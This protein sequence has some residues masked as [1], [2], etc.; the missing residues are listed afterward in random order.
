LP[1]SGVPA[2]QK[3][4]FMYASEVYVSR[5]ESRQGKH[6]R[7]LTFLKNQFRFVANALCAARRQASLI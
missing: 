5:D 4:F 6:R 7:D 2:I 3:E 1:G